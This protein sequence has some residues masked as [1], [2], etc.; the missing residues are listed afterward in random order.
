[1][2]P[3]GPAIWKDNSHFFNMNINGNISHSIIDQGAIHGDIDFDVTS[4]INMDP[5]FEDAATGDLRLKIG[6]PAIDKGLN[7]AIASETDLDRK[8][9][10]IGSRVDMGA[11]EHGSDQN[12]SKTVFLHP[13][14][15]I[16][17]TKSFDTNQLIFATNKI[18]STNITYDAMLGVELG[19]K[20]E[21][22]Q[23]A[24][25]QVQVIGCD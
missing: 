13:Q 11:Y 17:E 4:N 5:M 3:S 12:C 1:M 2:A 10:L 22:D 7:Q 9:R 16:N 18:T 6:S 25:F 23:G 15:F 8:T 21:I 19:Q 14:E 20:F 24:I